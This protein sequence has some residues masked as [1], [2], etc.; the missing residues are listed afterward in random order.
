MICRTCQTDTVTW[1]GDL[2]NPSGTKC[3]RCGQWNCQE[4]E[5]EEPEEDERP[6]EGDVSEG[7]GGDHS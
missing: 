5:E 6:P 1:Q 7:C 2:L 3:S 4:I